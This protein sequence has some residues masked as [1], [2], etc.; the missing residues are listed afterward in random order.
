[1]S[2][3]NQILKEIPI[4]EIENIKIGNAEDKEHATGCTVILCEQGAPAGIDVRGGGPASRE[5]ELLNPVGTI[6]GF[7]GAVL[8]AFILGL[9]ANEIV[10][11]IAT[12]VY[13][14]ATN[15]SGSVG[16]DK[17]GEIFINNGWNIVT[18]ICM[19]IFMIFHFPC[20]TT[21]I[22]IYKET[23]SIRWTVLSFLIPLL[24]GIILCLFVNFISLI[25]M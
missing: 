14:S 10:L 7:D 12:M 21:M 23:K 2:T 4:T 5:S 16:L 9:P 3:W 11:P 13:S 25:F 17:M 1:M 18:A 22:T 8:L 20:S 15:L 6:L 19:I 24:I